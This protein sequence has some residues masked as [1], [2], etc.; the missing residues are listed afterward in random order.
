[1]ARSKS[2]NRWI[3]EH[4]DDIFV[5][6]ARKQGYRSRAVYKLEEIQKKDKILKPGTVVVDLGAAPGAWSQYARQALGQQSGRVIALD[7][8]AMEP[9]SGVEVLCGDFAEAAVEEQLHQLLGDQRV[10][11]VLSDLAPNVTGEASID[12][13]RTMYLVELAME[14]ARLTLRKDGDFL[15]KVFQGEGF[16]SYFNQLKK[17]Y[18]KVITR[19]PKASRP[20]SRE[21]YLLCRGFQPDSA[22]E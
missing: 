21:V 1:M 7:I 22:D 12:Q 9:L 6:R 3:K 8:L 10:D 14:F 18:K 15:V 13:P 17:Q 4:E 19:K 5:Q 2:S 16:N 11:L 20:R